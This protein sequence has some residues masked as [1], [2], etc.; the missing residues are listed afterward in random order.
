MRRNITPDDL[1]YDI[2]HIE[3]SA[4]LETLLRK[5][6][7][8]TPDVLNYLLTDPIFDDPHYHQISTHI[9]AHGNIACLEIGIQHGLKIKPKHLQEAVRNNNLDILESKHFEEIFRNL[10]AQPE[11]PPSAELNN[12]PLHNI[13]TSSDKM[14]KPK[15]L[16]FLVKKGIPVNTH[17]ND[18][19]PLLALL[20]TLHLSEG[21]HPQRHVSYEGIA[22]IPHCI[23]LLENGAMLGEADISQSL[24]VLKALEE[25]PKPVGLFSRKNLTDHNKEKA[26][27]EVPYADILYL[28]G[29]LLE[30]QILESKLSGGKKN[31]KIS[32]ELIPLYEKAALSGNIPALIK[33]LHYHLATGKL[34]DAITWLEIAAKKNGKSRKEI[35]DQL[36]PETQLS[37]AHAIYLIGTRNLPPEALE[38]RKPASKHALKMAIDAF[39]KIPADSPLYEKAL[40]E[41]R[42]WLTLYNSHEK[43][44]ETLN[45]TLDDDSDEQ[46][47]YLLKKFEE[48]QKEKSAPTPLATLG[49]STSSK[50]IEAPLERETLHHIN[51]SVSQILSESKEAKEEMSELRT[52]LRALQILACDKKTTANQIRQHIEKI[53]DILAEDKRGENTFARVCAAHLEE[54]LNLLPSTAEKKGPTPS[55]RGP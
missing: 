17:F 18:Q 15:T 12:S 1:I 39:K 13:V 11:N 52:S 45:L 47:L 44:E 4:K 31:E 28:R 51:E 7:R 42:H 2:T 8:E 53:Q 26:Y 54:V 10:A 36:S 38:K 9:T 19:T 14:V 35:V 3:N 5:A 48:S 49:L 25:K 37:F 24:E 40:K 6:A 20:D 41:I 46:T 55:A 21:R 43:L 16:L 29:L 50:P 30:R 33:A 23:V 22:Y 34:D 32:Q 27:R